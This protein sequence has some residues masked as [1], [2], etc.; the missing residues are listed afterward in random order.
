MKCLITL[1]L[2]LAI[3]L[4]SASCKKT[5]TEIAS[6]FYCKVDGKQWT[7][8]SGDFKLR[9]AECQIGNK[10]SSI[11]ITATNTKS[12]EDF[13]IAVYSVRKVVTEGKYALN[14]DKYFFGS[15]GDRT[16]RGFYYREWV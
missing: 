16:I 12:L 11:F 13:A 6:G 2:P 14:S 1:I 4:S 15:Y 3:L 8:Y 10:G 9:E 7:P 5:S